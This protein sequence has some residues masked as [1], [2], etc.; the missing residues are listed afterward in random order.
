[1]SDKPEL[2][3]TV[4]LEPLEGQPDFVKESISYNDG[5]VP[6]VSISQRSRAN[7][8]ARVINSY[9]ALLAACK[10]MFA[11]VEAIERNN[12]LRG[13]DWLQL[14]DSILKT[15]A[16]IRA[17]EPA[18]ADPPADRPEKEDDKHE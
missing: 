10:E 1:M 15:R 11:L 17:A 7:A 6:Y 3:L 16:A 14:A 9:S 8:L 4:T 2:K 5:A 13:T 12:G 18:C